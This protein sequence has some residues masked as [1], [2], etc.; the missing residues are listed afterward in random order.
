MI[1]SDRK[2]ITKIQLVFFV[3]IIVLFC[4]L[5]LALPRI[6]IPL[7][8]AYILSLALT[9][10]VSALMAVRLSK[11]MATVFIFI[12]LA[13]LIGWPLAKIIPIL[14]NESQNF[15][16]VIPKIE[17]Y[18]IQQFQ[19]VREFVKL[20]TG[21]EIGDVYVYQ[22]LEE[23]QQWSTGFVVKIPNYL[24]NLMEWLF[25]VPFFTFFIIRDSDSFKKTLLS[26]TPNMIF[27]R[28]YYVIHV[29]NRQLGN[30][31]FA[32]FVEAVIVGGIITIGLL[33]M[34]I[35]YAV[36][37]GFVAGLTNIVP[38]L[39]PFLGVIPAIVLAMLEYGMT[40]PT[41]GAILILYSVAN[42]VDI[43][44]VFPFLVSKIVNLHPMIVAVSV[45]VGSHYMGITGMVIS[46]PVVAAIKLIITEIY[47]EIYTERSK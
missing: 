14:S 43:F 6:S 9:P 25:L 33:M 15:Q 5:V 26:F 44:F 3:S 39:G 37:L 38:Y 20:K 32:K 46:I 17:Q 13:I 18:V 40:S 19:F 8:I 35:K 2:N 7:S 21:H 24:A 42:V 28:F 23:L 22:G 30:Y 11:T 47:N 41:M 31:F 4:S 27:E 45:I 1:F 10:I 36:I 29:F 16:N 12:I 34:D